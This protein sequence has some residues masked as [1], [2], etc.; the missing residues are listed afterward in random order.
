[1]EIL[2]IKVKIGTK[3]F[4]GEGE[5]KLIS[6]LIGQFYDLVWQGWANLGW[7]EGP[8]PKNG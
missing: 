1:M 4:E 5:V 6:G 7:V 3:V 2:K 8:R